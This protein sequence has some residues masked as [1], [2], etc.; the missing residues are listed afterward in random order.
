MSINLRP[1]TAWI[2]QPVTCW[3]QR[4]M[5]V[6]CIIGQHDGC[7]MRGC[8]CTCGTCRHHQHRDA[9]T[10]RRRHLLRISRWALLPA[11]GICMGGMLTC[12]SG[13]FT[14]AFFALLAVLVS[15]LGTQP[16]TRGDRS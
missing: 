4:Q 14:A 5:S 16:P 1:L 15:H 3:R 6:T 12:Y 2:N 7:L 11:L 9:L 8:R 13:W 10:T